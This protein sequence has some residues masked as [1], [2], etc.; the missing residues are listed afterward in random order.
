M[1]T[2][3]KKFFPLFS[4]VFLCT[5]IAAQAAQINKVAAVVN[6]QVIT[7]MDL[8]KAALPEL[9]RARI[10]PENP[11]QAPAAKEILNKVLDV[12]IMDILIGQEAKRLK[13]AIS[14]QDVDNELARM[15]QTRKITREQFEAQLAAQNVPLSEV[16]AGMEKS[17]LR[18]KIMGMAVGRRVVVRPEEIK[19]YYET[20]KDKLYN[21]EG[22][23]WGFVVYP[24]KS[25]GKL[26]ASKVKN[27]S[28]PFGDAAR[29]Y[30][31]GPNKDAGGDMGPVP[32]GNLN[33]D[34]ESQL[35]SLKPGEISNGFEIKNNGMTFTAQVR[36]Y[37]PGGGEEKLLT[38]EEA[39]PRIDAILREPK[40]MERFEEYTTGLKSKAIIDKRI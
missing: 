20:H 36:L 32:W 17:L 5:V 21:R 31:V 12:M 23:H 38:L 14:P 40:A 3:V 4:A 18:Q 1:M 26:L 30:S 22:L 29:K 13:V 37:R 15:M 28:L 11:A 35:V 27:G 34:L 16:R 33:P 24:P 10:N 8:Q 25:D 7:M 39:T 2:P 9:A 6:G 19:A